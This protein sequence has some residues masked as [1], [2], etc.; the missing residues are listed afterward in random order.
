MS[1]LS[2][3]LPAGGGGKSVD[4]VASGTL[5][6]GVTVALNSDGTVSVAAQSTITTSIGT[7]TEYDTSGNYQP[8]RSAYDPVNNK[9]VIFYTNLVIVGTVSGSS[10]SFGTPVTV[11][12][13]NGYT[14][15]IAYDA[16]SGNIFL[17]FKDSQNSS[18]PTGILGTVSGTTISFGTRQ[19]VKSGFSRNYLPVCYDPNSEKLIG[20][21]SNIAV[22]ITTSGTTFTVGTETQFD[23]SE[24]AEYTSAVYDTSTSRV[25]VCYKQGSSLRS[26]VGTVGASTV[27]F[28]TP[29]IADDISTASTGNAVFDSYNNKVVIT[30]QDNNTSGYGL[31]IVGTVSG[32]SISFGTPVIFES[33]NTTTPSCVYDANARKVVVAY[34]VSS[35]S[36]RGEFVILT[37]SGTSFT[38]TS[39]AV[40]TTSRFQTATTV[41]NSVDK[42]VVIAS[43]LDLTNSEAWVFTTGYVDNASERFIGITDQAIADTA[44]GA[45][46]VQGGISDKA[47]GPYSLSAGSEFVFEAADS[48]YIDSVYDPVNQ[49]IVIAYA[50]YGNSAQGTAVVGT[51][52]GE[53]IS[54]GTPVVFNSI[55]VYNSIIYDSVN[56]KVVIAFAGVS[57]YGTGIV[58]TV[59]GTTI[60]FGTPTVFESAT[61]SLISAAYDTNAQKILIA[62]KDQGNLNYGTAIAGTV[63]GT[64]ISFGSANVF[65]SAN[66]DYTSTTYDSNAQK[67]VIAYRDVNNS[68]YGTARVATI[69]STS[70]GFGTV[71]VFNSGSTNYIASAYDINAQKHF[72]AYQD[73]SNS[74]YGTAVVGTV[75]GTSISFGSESVFEPSTMSFSDINCSYDSVAKKVLTFYRYG[76]SPNP[77]KGIIGTINGTDVSFDEAID[78]Y[79]NQP[80]YMSSAYDPDQNKTAVFYRDTSNSSYGTSSIASL[81][82]S[83]TPNTDYYVQTDGSLSTTVSSVPAG[84][85]LSTTS[86]LLEG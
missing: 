19:V 37:V 56:E 36:N 14:G 29:V 79:N 20:F 26:A 40:I 80:R 11:S 53:T 74:S 52:S 18:Y 38:F 7:P 64:S 27:T 83:L 17:L 16:S 12:G 55:G 61:T 30:Y 1:N 77:L 35:P 50:D 51:V 3:L 67:T 86:I 46:I 43:G 54:F 2:E 6:S 85:A 32:T 66:M 4:F 23:S 63:S 69:G 82:S 15:G 84:R 8:Q 31:G 65:E 45:V 9:V 78:V 58:G 76:A 34:R 73:D 57:N 68:G 5:G 21:Y 72:I 49:K 33:S 60:S 44:T 81:T 22:L 24:T 39:P 42:K 75:S 62:Y 10:I 48:R 70:I 59:S 47:I 13:A 28:G 71:V 25:V 41:Y